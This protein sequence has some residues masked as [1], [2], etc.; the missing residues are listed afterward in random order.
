M[1]SSDYH[2]N[3]NIFDSLC[4]M[5][6]DN[7]YKPRFVAIDFFGKDNIRLCNIET[8]SIDESKKY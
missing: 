7:I 1:T 4:N 3:K 6:V 5:F 8:Y 2:K